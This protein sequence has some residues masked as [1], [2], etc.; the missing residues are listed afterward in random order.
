MVML[1]P[2]D[3]RVNVLAPV[4]RGRK[5]EFKKELAAL[6]ARGFTRVRVDGTLALVR[7]RHQA[8][9]APQSHDRR[10]RRSARPQARHRASPHRIG[11]GRAES[12]GRH[13]R[14]QHAGR[15]RSPVLAPA[16]LH[17]LRRQHARDDAARL[18]VQL[19]ARRVHGLS[20][21]GRGLRFRSGAARARRIAVAAG[22]RDR[23]VGQRGPQARQGSADVA[24]QAF[25]DRPGAA[26][27]AAAEEDPRSPLLRHRLRPEGKGRIRSVPASKGSFP[28]S[29]GDTRRE[30]GSIR[31]GWSR[32]APSDRA[33]PARERG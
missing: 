3:E 18:L 5:G 28:T 16:G 32:I 14:D 11:R 13:R 31:K 4:V 7:R 23:P 30:A 27:Q 2:N 10:R 1:S 8:R 9:S 20:G 21:S 25:R 6:R 15:R 26:V 33:R 12:R 24:E 22:R 19:A 29:V 17:L